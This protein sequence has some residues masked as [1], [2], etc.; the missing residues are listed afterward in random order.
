MAQVHLTLEDDVLK[1]LMLGKR[2]EAVTKLLEQVFNSVLQAQ[3]TEQLNAEPYERSDERT[4]YRNGSRTRMLATRVGSLV[5]HVPKFRDGTLRA[6]LFSS[7]QRSEQALLLSLMEM[8]IQGVSTRKISEITE[9]LC[10]TSFSKS[11]VSAL[12]EQLDPVVE[13]FRDR[14]L[15]QHY[16]FLVVD[17]IYMKAREQHRIVSKGFLIATLVNDDGFREVLGFTVADG[18]SEEAWNEFFLS[19]KELIPSLLALPIS[20]GKTE[21]LPESIIVHQGGNQEAFGDYPV[22]LPSF[23]VDGIDNQERIVP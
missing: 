6:D 19:L 22:L 5:L 7:Y 10:G 13:A 16:P 18:E 3:A 23:H 20:Y 2:E 1:E 9:T 12:C 21:H 17:A 4:T 11:T 15:S 14:P 8:V